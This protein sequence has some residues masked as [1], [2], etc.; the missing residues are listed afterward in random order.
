[1]S[2]GA[3][4]MFHLIEVFSCKEGGISLFLEVGRKGLDLLGLLPGG[5]AAVSRQRVVDSTI[6]VYILSSQDTGPARATEGRTHVLKCLHIKYRSKNCN[7]YNFNSRQ[8]F[9]N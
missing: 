8:F 1:M 4:G 5:A 7:M 2:T 6:T 3:T 9:I